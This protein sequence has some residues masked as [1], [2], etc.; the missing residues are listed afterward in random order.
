MIVSWGVS[1]RLRGD[2]ARYLTYLAVLDEMN[3]ALGVLLHALGFETRLLG[4]GGATLV[5]GRRSSGAEDVD[6]LDQL[7]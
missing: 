2:D 3:A 1:E 5:T 4:Q 6:L 7:G